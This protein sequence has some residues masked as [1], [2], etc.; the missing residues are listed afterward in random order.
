MPSL[1]PATREALARLVPPT[2]SLANPV[3]TTAGVPAETFTA[4]LRAVLAD[5]GVDGVVAISAP[6][7]LADLGPAIVEA[8]ATATKPVVAVRLDQGDTVELVPLPDGSRM[9]AFADPAVAVAAYARAVQYAAWREAPRGHV[10]ELSGVDIDAG[11]DIVKAALT[12]EPAGGW[13]GPDETAALLGSF[14]IP[15]VESVQV[16]GPEAAVAAAERLGTPVAL[17]A[18]VPGLLHK[19]DRGGV[20]L[21]L[22]D[23]KAVGA[24]YGTLS[25]RFG[26]ELR[27]AVVQPMAVP[28][29]ETLVGVVSDAVFG[30]LV[31]FGAGGVVTDL[32]GD[33]ATRLAPLTD[34]DAA[35]M[36]RG[37]RSS[38]LLFGY[39]GAAPSDHAA[40]EDVL[41]RVGALAETLPEVAEL[42][43][44]P[45]VVYPSGCV[46][47]DA[48]ARIV[49]RV[50]VDPYLRQLR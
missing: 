45:L 8:V 10:P 24:A 15:V 41:L 30:P 32:L 3:D 6:T 35:A 13:L 25:E 17:K 46:A 20:L 21:D 38:P 22:A 12:R 18:V 27:G 26:A 44:N 42:E 23:S 37:L 9:P 19:S 40:V 33:R 28:G 50:P 48:R 29:V 1:A 7:A 2:A 39:R 5:P 31:V 4:C 34:L 16:E 49:P 11:R 47:V 14:G 43:L 36:V